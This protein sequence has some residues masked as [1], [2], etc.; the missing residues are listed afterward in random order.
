MFASNTWFKINDWKHF[1]YNILNLIENTEAEKEVKDE[2]ERPKRG[3]VG[4]KYTS[5]NY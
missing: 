2:L 3:K 5:S 1:I 4:Q